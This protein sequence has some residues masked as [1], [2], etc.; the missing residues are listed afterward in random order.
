MS[1]AGRTVRVLAPAKV[2]PWLE[3]LGRR[4][5]GYHEL[6]TV[7]V[8]LDLADVVEARAVDRPGIR[9]AVDGPFASADVPR[10]ATNLAAAAAQRVLSA[11][12]DACAIDRG[13][14]LEFGLTKNVPSRAGLGG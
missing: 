12:L 13:V 7:M 14:G 2:N 4:S 6:D 3:V 5:D 11:A 1:I 8:A 9:I 10:D